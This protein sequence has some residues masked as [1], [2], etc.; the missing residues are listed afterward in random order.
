MN[1]LKCVGG[2]VQVENEILKSDEKKGM[3]VTVTQECR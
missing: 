1:E 2:N 3:G